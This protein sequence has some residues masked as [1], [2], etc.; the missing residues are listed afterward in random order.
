[1][2]VEMVSFKGYGRREGRQG[3]HEIELVKDRVVIV[4]VGEDEFVF[5]LGLEV[6]GVFFRNASVGGLWGVDVGP[7]EDEET[8]VCAVFVFEGFVDICITLVL[9]LPR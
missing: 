2:L 1:M 6:V 5:E 4:G 3:L 8:H 9:L 7:C